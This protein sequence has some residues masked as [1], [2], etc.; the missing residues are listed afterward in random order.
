MAGRRSLNNEKERQLLQVV[1][2]LNL[3]DRALVTTQWLTGFRIS[4]VL[5]LTVGSVYRAGQVVDKIG[6]T[7]RNLKGHYGRTR[8]V[9]VL[10]EH[11]PCPGKLPQ[12]MDTSKHETIDQPHFN[13]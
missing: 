13:P 5:S 8:W 11:A 2:A 3:R 9:P 1:R 4:E 6:A 7:P 12:A 10:S